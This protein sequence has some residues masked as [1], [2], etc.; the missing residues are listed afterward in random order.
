MA[1][2]N[3]VTCLVS[4]GRADPTVDVVYFDF[5]RLLP[6]SICLPK[7]PCRQIDKVWA[8]KLDSEVV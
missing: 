7:H 3:E 2:Y 5:V 6:K 4:E 1:F 8:R